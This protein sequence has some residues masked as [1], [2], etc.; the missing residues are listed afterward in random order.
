MFT[1]GVFLPVEPKV[2]DCGRDEGNDH[3]DPNMVASVER[4]AGA[5]AELLHLVEG[6][7]VVLT[8]VRAFLVEVK[9]AAVA[10]LAGINVAADQCTD[11][12]CWLT[13]AARDGVL[14]CGVEGV[15]GGSVLVLPRA[16]AGRFESAMV[17]R[18]EVDG[19]GKVKL[20]IEDKR[21]AVG[22]SVAL[23]PYGV[24]GLHRVDWGG[25]TERK[26]KTERAALAQRTWLFSFYRHLSRKGKNWFFFVLWLE[27]VWETEKER[28]RE[29][30]SIAGVGRRDGYK[31]LC[32]V[33][34]L[35][36]S[37]VV[38]MCTYIVPAVTTN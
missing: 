30:E 32:L 14:G 12:P 31:V 27:K 37:L 16:S 17:R 9:V 29:N 19:S 35:V 3:T 21:S 23:F 18:A 13:S 15:A 20:R 2:Q 28:E 4:L 1:K 26:E 38:W 33:G 34:W 24:V 7:S 8:W 6:V 11:R 36:V 25:E 10:V 22:G 5:E